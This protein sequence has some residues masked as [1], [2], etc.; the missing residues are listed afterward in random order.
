MKLMHEVRGLRNNNP[1]NLEKPKDFKWDGQVDA[2]PGIP[3]ETRFCR[4]SS[5]DHGVRAIFR[6]LKT[7]R[8]KY[9][10]DT[11]EGIIHR[12]APPSDNDTESYI[13]AV[14][15]NVYEMSDYTATKNKKLNYVDYPFIVESIINHENGFCPFTI[16][17]IKNVFQWAVPEWNNKTC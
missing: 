10:L 7:Y 14:C 9:S 5:V 12:Y 16:E 6:I 11:I 8:E 2:L 4:F 17:Y 13:R 1:G 3:E 15:L